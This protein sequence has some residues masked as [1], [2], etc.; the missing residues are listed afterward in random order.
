VIAGPAAELAPK[1]VKIGNCSGSE[2]DKIRVNWFD[3][4]VG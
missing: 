2:I 3:T 4:V 1:V